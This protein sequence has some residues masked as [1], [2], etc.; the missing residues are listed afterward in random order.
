M[1]YDENILPLVINLVIL[2]TFTLDDLLMLLGENWW[3]SLLGPKGSSPSA[4]QRR[5]S[6]SGP[7][8]DYQDLSASHDWPVKNPLSICQ[9]GWREIRNALPVV[10]WVRWGPCALISKLLGR[11]CWPGLDYVCDAGQVTLKSRGGGGS[12]G[13]SWWGCAAQFSKSRPYFP[14][15]DQKMTSS[16]PVFRPDI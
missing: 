4:K 3:W 1:V 10:L 14:I 12:P 6:C 2:I 16:T 7:P 15:S 8:P 9:S 5:N 11:R 13:N